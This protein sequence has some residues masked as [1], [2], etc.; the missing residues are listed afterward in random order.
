MNE[1]DRFT[2]VTKIIIIQN[3]RNISKKKDKLQ[4]IFNVLEGETVLIYCDNV[5][6]RECRVVQQENGQAAR[7]QLH[8][9][10]SH[11]W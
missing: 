4:L 3:K 11:T 8:V 10:S 6:L 1:I 7:L 9:H 2:Y 5:L